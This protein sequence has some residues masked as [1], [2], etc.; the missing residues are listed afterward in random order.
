MSFVHPS[1]GRPAA[2]T[3]RPSPG[4]SA[5]S[6]SALPAASSRAVHKMS[7]LIYQS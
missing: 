4:G 7:P 5:G 2:V 6:S 3:T 1:W